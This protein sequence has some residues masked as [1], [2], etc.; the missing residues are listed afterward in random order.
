MLFQLVKHYASVLSGVTAASLLIASPSH[1]Q[2]ANPIT[3][4]VGFWTGTGTVSLASGAKQNLLCQSAYTVGEVT[5]ITTLQMVLQCT[6]K[7]DKND[8]FDLQSDL[9]YEEGVISG[10]WSEVMRGVFGKVSG[11]TAG[12]QIQVIAESP[13]FQANIELTTRGQFQSIK[14]ISP[15]NMMSE[16]LISLSRKSLSPRD[17]TQVGMSET[18]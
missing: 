14:I 5:S 9:R 1:A 17:R 2:N 7:A 3:K 11:A 18:K 8:S 13:V 4:L 16:V 15:G 10:K 12:E 6:N